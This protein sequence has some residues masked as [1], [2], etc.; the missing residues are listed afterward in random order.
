MAYFLSSSTPAASSEPVVHR[1]RVRWFDSSKG[2]GFIQP[3]NRSQDAFVHM[4]DLRCDWTSQGHECAVLYTG[5]YV[6]YRL[7]I[8]DDG[9]HKA[10]NVTGICAGPLLCEA[11]TFSFTSFNKNVMDSVVD[12]VDNAEAAPAKTA[13]GSLALE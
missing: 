8:T 12:S 10:F 11:G 9:K 2:Y 5:E 1:G 13:E 6:E 7:E 3:L 4:K